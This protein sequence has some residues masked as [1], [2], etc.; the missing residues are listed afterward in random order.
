[1]LNLIT[2]FYLVFRKGYF[3]KF[4]E[5]FIEGFDRKPFIKNKEFFMV[6][7]I[8]SKIDNKC[9]VDYVSTF[10]NV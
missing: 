5:L 4:I 6:R 10:K 7:I 2:F 8:C 9:I 3:K 1:M